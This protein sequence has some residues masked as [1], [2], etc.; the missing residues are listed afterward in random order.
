MIFSQFSKTLFLSLGVLILYPASPLR[1][2]SITR[3]TSPEILTNSFFGDTS[4]LTFKDIEVNGDPRA[5]GIFQDD[6]FLLQSGVVLSTGNVEDAIGVNEIDGGIQ[7]LFGG[8]DL[9]TDLGEPGE[10]LTSLIFEFDVDESKDTLYFQ[11]VFGSEEFIEYGGSAFNDSF[12][13]LLNGINLATL[14]DGRPTSINQLFFDPDLSTES[15]TDP[16]H[17]D[18]RYNPVGEGLV[19]DSSKLDGYSRP[20]LFSG[21]LIQNSRNRLEISVEDVGDGIFDSLVFLKADTFG[22]VKPPSILGDGLDGALSSGNDDDAAQIPEPV[23]SSAVLIFGSG[24]LLAF[25]RKRHSSP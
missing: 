10:D 17:P 1:A 15:D 18:F 12:E 25:C 21:P 24:F 19:S 6:P 13:L 2:F 4:G 3:S 9:S 7:P 16:Y 23:G 11:Y 14:T 22:T 8:A 5:F 20:L